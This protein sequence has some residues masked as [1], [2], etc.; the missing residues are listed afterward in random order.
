MS[1]RKLYIQHLTIFYIFFDVNYIV[2]FAVL[3]QGMLTH[4]LGEASLYFCMF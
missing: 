3:S 1:R 2:V 4:G